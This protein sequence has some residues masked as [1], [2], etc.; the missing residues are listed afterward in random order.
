MKIVERNGWKL[1]DERKSNSVE[2]IKQ[3][4]LHD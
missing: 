3:H 2:R 1:S 4:S